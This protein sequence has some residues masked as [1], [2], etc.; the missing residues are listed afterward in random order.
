MMSVL[1]DEATDHGVFACL[2][3]GGGVLDNSWLDRRAC[4]P[5]PR[6]EQYH[7]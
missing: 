7:Q 3:C 2:Y 5:T 1:N 6:G 4:G